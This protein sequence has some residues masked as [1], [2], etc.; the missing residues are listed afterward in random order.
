[1][2]I[3]LLALLLVGLTPTFA[4]AQNPRPRR[5]P[6]PPAL[7]PAL[8]DRTPVVPVE[9]QNPTGSGSN[10]D[11]PKPEEDPI[12]R[13]L[14]KLVKAVGSLE[15]T[16]KVQAGSALLGALYSRQSSLEFQ[17]SE[18]EKSLRAMRSELS[19]VENR[20]QNIGA[21][22]ATMAFASRDEAEARV[23]SS[24]QARADKLRSELAIAENGLQPK[25]GELSA[26]V[27][28]IEDIK[29]KLIASLDLNPPTDG[30]PV[31]PGKEDPK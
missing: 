7:P 1:M 10:G 14:D 9:G 31:E 11:A 30:P 4:H 15:R 27:A 20:Q 12:V 13:E 26:L 18:T 21:E 25:K 5:R 6:T 22:L 28:Q 19:E 29:Q 16:G 2:R 17:I 23:R 3:L 24:L 8:P